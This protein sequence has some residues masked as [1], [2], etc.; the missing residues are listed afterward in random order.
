M[1]L[2]NCNLFLYYSRNFHN[3]LRFTFAPS[4]LIVINTFAPSL[5]IV[6]NIDLICKMQ[7]LGILIIGPLI[8][9]S[10]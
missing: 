4:L 1:I 10:E 6:I 7:I 5:L 8:H 9:K 2:F 3:R